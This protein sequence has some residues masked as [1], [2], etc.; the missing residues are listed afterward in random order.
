[1]IFV[2]Q[3]EAMTDR[4]SHD[5]DAARV[6]SSTYR[7][8]QLFHVTFAKRAFS[9]QVVSFISISGSAHLH[10]IAYSGTDK[11]RTH[12]RSAR[13]LTLRDDEHGLKERFARVITRAPPSTTTR[14]RRASNDASPRS[15]ACWMD[16]T[17]RACAQTSRRERLSGTRSPT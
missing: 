14:H 16:V 11:E 17:R 9:R 6:L 2:I 10:L 4:T 3:Y 5:A 1:M 15:A 7:F 8:R 13:S 12:E